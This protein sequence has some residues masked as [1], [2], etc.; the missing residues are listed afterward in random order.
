MIFDNL[1]W[2]ALLLAISV[3]MG[4]L[5]QAIKLDGSSTVFPIGK[6]A[7]DEFAKAR[8]NGASV[9]VGLSGTGGGFKKFCRGEIDIADASRP[10]VAGEI[11]TCKRTGIEYIELPISYDAIIVV[12]N[13]ANSFV[14]SFSVEEL[15]KLWEPAAQGEIVK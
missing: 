13:A 5:G 7:A 6:I 2:I 1:P 9:I 11:D 15:K 12:V 14:K 3:P 8:K 10:I 4:A